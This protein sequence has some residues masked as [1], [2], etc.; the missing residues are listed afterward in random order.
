MTKKSTPA[1]RAAKAAALETEA[2][3]ILAATPPSDSREVVAVEFVQR[4]VM[5]WADL[6]AGG[7]P[8]QTM[9][10]GVLGLQGLALVCEQN[11]FTGRYTVNGNSVGAFNGD[12]SDIITRKIRDVSRM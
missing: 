9:T 4:E 6:T 7:A 2:E 11:S 5:A 10:N 12:L 1:A 3:T 8:K